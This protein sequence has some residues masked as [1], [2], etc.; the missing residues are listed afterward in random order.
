MATEHERAVR[1]AVRLNEDLGIIFQR[2]GTAEHPNGRILL[3]YR[4]ARRA[5]DGVLS[6]SG[7]HAWDVQEVLSELRRAIQEA[8]RP[9]LQ[10][11]STAAAHS[12]VTQ[13]GAYGVDVGGRSTSGVA[14]AVID[15]AMTAIMAQ[16]DA[17]LAGVRAMVETDADPIYITGD[18]S[19]QGVLVPTVVTSAAAFW[20]VRVASSTWDWVASNWGG[21]IGTRQE[22]YK[23]AIAAI[24]ERTTDCCLQVHGQVQ[25]MRDPFKLT[26]TPRYADELMEP[27]FHWNC[28]TAMALVKPEDVDDRL[29]TEMRAAAR[30][31]RQAR[32]ETGQR[33]EIHPSHARSGR[34]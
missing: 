32:E 16:L 20:A 15:Q 23:Q 8:T 22:F 1:A 6:K 26:G 4:N 31:E 9:A 3:A 34:G 27:P 19:R 10:D 30:A 5:L 29:S 11:S 18:E 17:Q 14:T 33:Q 13:L 28:R 2:F 24:D 21:G 25:P 12:A 7:S